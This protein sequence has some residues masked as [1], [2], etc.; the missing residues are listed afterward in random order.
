MQGA[1]NG[2]ASAPEVQMYGYQETTELSD[3]MYIILI[4]EFSNQINRSRGRYHEASEECSEKIH[5]HDEC[6]MLQK[7]QRE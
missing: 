2:S 5:G 6:N 7:N 1:Q 3:V 4:L